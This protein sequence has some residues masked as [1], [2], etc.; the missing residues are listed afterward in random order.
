[1]NNLIIRV[2]SLIAVFSLIFIGA[3]GGDD[4][5]EA[6]TGIIVI[7][8]TD[9][10]DENIS[11]I[12]VTTKLI[13]GNVGGTGN[14]SGWQTLLD[15]EKNFDLIA[16]AG[17][18]KT[19]GETEIPAATYN[20]IRMHVESV[21]VTLNGKDVEAKVPSGIIKLV[22]PYEIKADEKTVVT[23]DFDAEQSVVVTGADDIIFKPVVKLL[24]RKGDEPFRAETT[25]RE[26]EKVGEMKVQGVSA[27]EFAPM[28]YGDKDGFFLKINT[29]EQPEV[30]IETDTIVIAGETSVDAAVSIGDEFVD[31]NLDGTFEK[32][33]NL[34]EDITIL[35]VIASTSDGQQYDQVLT[36]IYA[37]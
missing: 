16:V 14:E 6:D 5:S 26:E 1:M 7:G 11:A 17:I 30:I 15:V 24:V 19:L 34:E 23:F 35:E 37:P 18:E 21:V 9:K 28:I 32:V 25:T 13:E 2:L 20:Q 31:V 3:C 29:P 27:S 8:V 36:I 22:Q 4:S 10:P 12:K 33:V